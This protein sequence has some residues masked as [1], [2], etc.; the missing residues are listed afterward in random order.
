MSTTKSLILLSAVFVVL[1][2]CHVLDGT[3]SS[4]DEE[5]LNN[6]VFFG[7]TEID[8]SNPFKMSRFERIVRNIVQFKPR[9]VFHTGDLV[10]DTENKQAWEVFN[11]VIKN[12]RDSSSFYPALG[13]HEKNSQWI[14]NDNWDLP[15]NEE[16]YSVD[17][18]R[19]HVVVLHSNFGYLS[20]DPD[21]S[22]GRVQYDWLIADLEEASAQ[23]RDIILVFHH[24][25]FSTGKEHPG[26]ENG[27]G[28][29]LL[30]LIHQ[31]DIRL[32]V[33]GHNHAYEHIVVNGTHYLTTGGGGRSLYDQGE[34]KDYSIKY[35]KAYHHI[36]LIPKD[37]AFELWVYDIR[38]RVIDSFTIE[39]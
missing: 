24:P 31:Y 16:Y 18:D 12:I 15:N 4:I 25:L 11:R 27:I 3:S 32:C 13:N 9:A 23:D 17:I 37:D 35:I 8:H 1:S 26:D 20:E 10:A 29:V 28:H 38:L 39:L 14:W 36:V 21:N 30:P 19:L 34:T 2:A 22:A 7:D 6:I 5:Q 33:N